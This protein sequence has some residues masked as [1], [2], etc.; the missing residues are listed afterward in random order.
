[1][2]DVF[3]ADWIRVLGREKFFIFQT[4]EYDADPRGILMKIFDFL[5]LGEDNDVKSSK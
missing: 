2:Y 3:I 5:D 4:E 1:M